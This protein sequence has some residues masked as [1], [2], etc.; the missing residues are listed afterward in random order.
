MPWTEG[1]QEGDGGFKFLHF[2]VLVVIRYFIEC[3]GLM[4][5]GLICEFGKLAK[6]SCL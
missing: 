4:F 5:E 3:G 6:Y 1:G 2:H